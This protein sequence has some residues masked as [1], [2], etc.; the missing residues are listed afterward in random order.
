MICLRCGYCC[1]MYMVIIVDNPE[2]GII[3]S[4]LIGKIEPKKCKHLIGSKCGEFK[5]SIHNKSWYNE[6]PCFEHSQ[7]EKENSN[8]RIGEKVLKESSLQK[9]IYEYIEEPN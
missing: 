4:N 2:L 6:T 7:F 3:E 5:C 1:L 9:K 8:C